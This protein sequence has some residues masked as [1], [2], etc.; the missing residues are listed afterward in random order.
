VTLVTRGDDL[1]PATHI[2]RLLQALLG[3]D[4]PDYHHHPLLTDDT[5]MRFAKRDQAMTLHA[6]R[7]EGHSAENIKKRLKID[8]I[9][10]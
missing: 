8:E 1:F 3:Y 2:H 7:Q 5:G 6:L 10:L 4:T 9:L